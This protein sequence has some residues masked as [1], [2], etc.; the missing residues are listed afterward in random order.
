MAG[1]PQNGRGASF[2]V[3][4]DAYTTGLLTDS[5]GNWLLCTVAAAT[6][7]PSSKPGFAIGCWMMDLT[8]GEPYFYRNSG[9]ATSCTFTQKVTAS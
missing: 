7:V 2:G 3:A 9:S 8:A 4:I 5:D 6:N 1:I